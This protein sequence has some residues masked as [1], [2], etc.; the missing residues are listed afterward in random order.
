MQE[1][2]VQK[3]EYSSKSELLSM[4]S[5]AKCQV[6]EHSYAIGILVYEYEHKSAHEELL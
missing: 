2:T 1:I 3:I 5:K 4:V 6:E